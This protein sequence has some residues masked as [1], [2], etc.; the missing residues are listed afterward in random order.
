MTN[1][2]LVEILRGALVESVHRGAVAV[3][4]AD[5]AS[6][7]ELGDVEKAVYPRSAVKPL[8]ALALVESGAVDLYGFGDEEL[9]LACASHG[10]EPA[11]VAVAQRMLGQAGLEVSALECG[12][13]WPNNQTAT[14]AL[15]RTGGAPSALH[16][17]C[18]G[19]HAGFL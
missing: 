4:D 7:L 15:A 17:N 8:Q 3:V 6:V 14:Q 16:N 2:V 1:P 5:G 18:S 13:H 12:T 9:A 11:H 10:G 19:K